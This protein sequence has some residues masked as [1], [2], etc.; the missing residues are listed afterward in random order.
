M[1]NA[2]SDLDAAFED[3]QAL[4]GTGFTRLRRGH[5]LLMQ[6]DDA[7]R[8]R[9]WIGGLLAQGLVHPLGAVRRPYVPGQRPAPADAPRAQL[10]EAVTIAFSQAGLAALGLADAEANPFPSAFRGGMAEASRRELLDGDAASPWRWGD[11]DGDAVHV[12]VSH[13]WVDGAEPSRHLDPALL[14]DQ[15]W[16]ARVVSTC[17]GYIDPPT[18]PEPGSREPFGFRDGLSQPVPDGI[19]WS[20]AEMRARRQAGKALFDDRRVA[21]GEF[22]LGHVNEYREQA[23][24]PG[25]AWASAPARSFADFGRNGSYMAVRQIV[26]HVDVFRAFEASCPVPDIAER[27]MGRR[28]DGR[29]LAASGASQTGLD[30]FRYLQD[31]ADGFGCPRGAHVRRANPRDALSGSLADGAAGARLHRLLRRGRVY[32]EDGVAE[33][34]CEVGQGEGLM[35]I[36]LNADLERQFEF[37]QRSWIGGPR[38]GGLSNEQDPILGTAP[39]RGFTLQGLPVGMRIDG[40]PRFT[41]VVGGGYFFLPGL[42]ALAFI[43]A[44]PPPSA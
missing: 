25:V 38:F 39:G 16:R 20:Q 31:D 12:L 3:I 15:G 44:G 40:L 13:F 26:Q 34:S 19:A 36:A 10:D 18:Q 32:A 11:I 23:Y 2:L 42:A 29:S 35:F 33:S 4:V 14:A 8:A 43:A 6:V 1:S 24:C 30:G 9:D 22:V 5:Y 17:P 28:R 21:L 7:A 37:I 41:T 27:M